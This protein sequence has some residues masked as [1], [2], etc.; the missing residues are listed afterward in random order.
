MCWLQSIIVCLIIFYYSF[1]QYFITRLEEEIEEAGR[2]RHT[3]GWIDLVGAAET[4]E[5]ES[6]LS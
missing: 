4:V 2:G 5:L 3:G 6:P 1:L